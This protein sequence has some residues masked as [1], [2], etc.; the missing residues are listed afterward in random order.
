VTGA[1][2]VSDPAWLAH[3]LDPAGARV[4]FIHVDRATRA[5]V[6]FLTDEHLLGVTGQWV[7]RG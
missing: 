5:K 2:F 6:P 7:G 3:R 1:S 4:R